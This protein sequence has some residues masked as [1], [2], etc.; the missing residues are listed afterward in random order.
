[1]IDPSI[2]KKTLS[3]AKIATG[4][5]AVPGAATGKVAFNAADAEA[6]AAKGERFIVSG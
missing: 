5:D 1:M 3:A 4:I 6:M 2:E